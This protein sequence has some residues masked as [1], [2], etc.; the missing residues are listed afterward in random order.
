MTWSD[1]CVD[2]KDDELKNAKSDAENLFG[3]MT[4]SLKINKIME[5]EKCSEG[6]AVRKLLTHH[7]GAI[8]ADVNIQQFKSRN[9]WGPLKNSVHFKDQLTQVKIEELLKQFDDVKE[10]TG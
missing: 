5:V 6:D 9:F 7:F 10:L 3:D 8:P 1:F 4:A 2:F